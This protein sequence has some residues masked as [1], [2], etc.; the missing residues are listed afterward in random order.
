MRV[1][2]TIGCL[3]AE[4]GGMSVCTYNLLSTMNCLMLSEEDSIEVS[5]LTTESKVK[6]EPLLG[7]DEWIIS[8]ENDGIS[9]YEYSSNIRK[10]LKNSN[11]DLYHTNGLWLY[12]NHVTCRNARDKNVPYIISTHGM[13]YREAL[14]RSYWKKL[15]FRLLFFDKDVANADC[16]HATCHKE[17][18]EIRRFGYK[19]PIAV[20]PNPTYHPEY[21][22]EVY[23]ERLSLIEGC[24]PRMFGYLGRL[25][26]RKKVENI[27]YAY[28]KVS[29]KQECELII[30]GK[31]DDKY[32]HF[33]KS[34]VKRLGLRNVFFC[35]FVSGR[36]KYENLAKLACLFVPSD[37][38]NFGMVV[39]EALSV[40]TP[41][42]ASLGTPWKELK[43]DNCGW[44]QD[45]SVENIAKIM[46]QSLEV[47]T[48]TLI[49][50]G[51]RGRKLVVEKYS[52]EIVANNM[53]ELYR[54]IVKGGNKP[55][56]VYEMR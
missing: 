22:D 44:W 51:E 12:V 5:V 49:E 40:G 37:F 27:L 11:Y 41:V 6:D 45:C 19:G 24:N 36:E 9:H 16:I 14:Q 28:A 42:M 18:E 50:M 39:T 46:H 32:E 48:E 30:M 55:E 35:G 52:A 25:H 3:S 47:S 53:A 43:T 17:M 10:W 7:E 21:L 38:E 15:P 54:W 34:E 1:L 4:L 33:L 13:L 26:P 8:V 29:Q 56:F 20:I 23:A 2:Q 31:G